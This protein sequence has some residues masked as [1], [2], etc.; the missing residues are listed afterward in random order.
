MNGDPCFCP[1]MCG[2]WAQISAAAPSRKYVH[3]AGMLVCRRLRR[4]G[5]LRSRALLYSSFEDRQWHR[6]VLENFVE[7]PKVK[8]WSEDCLRLFPGAH[9]RKVSN[10]VAAR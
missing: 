4:L 6:A 3:R 5:E 1:V 2:E 9:P 8:L 10:L 7:L